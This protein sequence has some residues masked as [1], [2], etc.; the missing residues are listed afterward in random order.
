[1]GAPPARIS[2]VAKA[3]SE[4]GYDVSVITA[5]PN[6]P[7]GKIKNGYDKKNYYQSYENGIHIHRVKVFLPKHLGRFFGRLIT[8]ASFSFFSF[9]Y[10]LS[11]IRK[12]QVVIIQNPPLFSG[13]VTCLVKCLSNSKVINWC[14]DIWPDLLIELG[15][16]KKNSVISWS[17]KLIQRINFACS[18][19]VAVTTPNS[20][21]A[22]QKNYNLK[23]VLLWRNAVDT[24]FFKP[25]KIGFDYRKYWGLSS[26]KFIVGYAG[27]HGNFQN[28]NT[29]LDACKLL[30]H[31][32]SN[33]HAVLVGDGVQK[34]QLN[35]RKLTENI[36]N[37]SLFDPLNRDAMP[38]LL[39]S[40]DAIIIPLARPMPTTIPSKFYE[41]LSAGKPLIV[42]SDSEI[43]SMVDDYEIGTVYSC[44]NEQSLARA[45]LSLVD[46]DKDSFK[47]MGKNARKL[48]LEFD[49]QK[50]VNQIESDIKNLY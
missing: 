37:L 26:S 10:A 32:G 4:K 21:K 38:D 9:F 2:E 28:L 34:E 46:L 7:Y 49:R 22:L 13:L 6:R 24:E 14:S 19:A 43:S 40:F 35:K 11:I 47:K 5:V 1:M 17:M 8:E 33:I 42:V 15:S 44:G 50:I 16:L 25:Y 45:I 23:N 18:D 39:Q 12:S 36:Q 3:L 41:S 20:L 29:V 27:L 48:S 30:T 31:R